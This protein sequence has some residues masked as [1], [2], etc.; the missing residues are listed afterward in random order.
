MTIDR[1]PFPAPYPLIFGGIL[2]MDQVY[3]IFIDR[4]SVNYDERG[5]YETNRQGP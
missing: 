3:T 5:V 1:E 4:P 2:E